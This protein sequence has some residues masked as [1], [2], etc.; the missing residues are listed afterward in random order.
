MFSCWLVGGILFGVVV[1]ERLSFGLRVR[2]NGMRRDG[3]RFGLLVVVVLFCLGSFVEAVTLYVSA[4]GNDAWSGR[5]TKTDRGGNDGPLASLNGARDEIRKIKRRV[6]IT[7][8][9]RVIVSGGI[10]ASR[11]H[12]C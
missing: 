1:L 4:D 5:L 9:I 8:S 6:G 12:F 7:A 10:I 11:S 2:G 3:I